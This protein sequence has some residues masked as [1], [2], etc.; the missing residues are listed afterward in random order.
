MCIFRVVMP[1]K[2]NSLEILHIE[3]WRISKVEKVP[4]NRNETIMSVLILHLLFSSLSTSRQRKQHDLQQ[5]ITLHCF[6]ACIHSVHFTSFIT[7]L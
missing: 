7:V 2:I 6:L 1:A 3:L 4:Q 5:T